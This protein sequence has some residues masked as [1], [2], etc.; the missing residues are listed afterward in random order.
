[1]RRQPPYNKGRHHDPAYFLQFVQKSD[2][3]WEWTGHRNAAGYGHI[4]LDGQ[5][6]LAHRHSWA[7]FKGPIPDGLFCLHRCD[8]PPCVRPDHLFMGTK[9]DNAMD[10]AAKGRH[11]RQR[12]KKLAR[13]C[14]ILHCPQHSA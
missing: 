1:M 7:L 9:K 13:R 2:G 12:K 4:S 5:F 6:V 11:H 8:N 3:C 10:M 14:L